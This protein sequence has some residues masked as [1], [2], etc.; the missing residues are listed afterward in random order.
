MINTAVACYMLAGVPILGAVSCLMLWSDPAR[1]RTCSVILTLVSLVAAIGLT[2]YLSVS[3]EG[4]LFLY[5]LPLAA[6]ASLLGQP[7][8]QTHR[9]PGVITLVSLGLGMGILTNRELFGQLLLLILFALTAFLLYRYYSTQRPMSWLGI[10]TFVLGGTFILIAAVTSSSV[11][12]TMSVLVCAILLPLLPFQGGYITALTKLP[13]NL[14]SFVAVLFPA[15][16]LDELS[17][18]ITNVSPTAQVTIG[19]LALSGGLFGAM[20][21]LAQSRVLLL[22]SYG[23][24]SFFSIAWW[25]VASAHIVTFQTGV[26]V[27]AVGVTTSGLILAWQVIRTRCGDGVDPR[28]ISGLSFS[29]PKYT[30]LVSLIAIAAMG[31]PPFGVFAGFLGMLLTSSFSSAAGLFAIFLMWL[32]A[33]WY[34]LDGVQPLLFGQKRADLRLKD[35]RGS[36]FGALLIILCIVA[37]MGVTPAIVLN[38]AS[39]PS[40]TGFSP[41]F[42]LWN[43]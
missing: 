18:V 43:G 8:H 13:G 20:K 36:E 15:L 30:V 7:A 22:V 24:L 28:A 10:G 3:S 6:C 39:I 21:A 38:A 29:M 26:F 42:A 32:A 40:M 25:F 14:P 34:I 41:G 17:Q 11:S 27:G 35:L 5:L 23:S 31:L 1:F 2:P 37:V 33:S 4:F 16:G 12:T 9:L 19:L